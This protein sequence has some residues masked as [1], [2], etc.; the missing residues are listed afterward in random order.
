MA[1]ANFFQLPGLLSHCEAVCARL[2]DI[3][4]IVLYVQHY[5][6]QIRTII[7]SACRSVPTGITSMPRC[8]PRES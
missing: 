5:L 3:D 4:N 7:V 1:A 6:Q 2:V 8:M